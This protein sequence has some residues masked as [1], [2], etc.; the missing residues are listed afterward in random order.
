MLFYSTI[1][2]K[3]FISKYDAESD[4]YQS[5]YDLLSN[6]CYPIYNNINVYD[7]LLY[8]SRI[9]IVKKEYIARPDLISQAMYGT[10]EYADIIC[11]VNGLQNPFEL[12]EDMQLF[13]PRREAIRNFIKK[14]NVSASETISSDDFNT[15]NIS[16]SDRGNK[17]LLNEKRSPAE[18]TVNDF[19]YILNRDLGV[20]FY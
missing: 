2:E 13:I 12:N 15:D 18:A 20:V 8:G 4:T 6:S 17:K 9:I 16:H 3:G 19:N 14:N 10:D 7:D 5:M 1:E 11:K